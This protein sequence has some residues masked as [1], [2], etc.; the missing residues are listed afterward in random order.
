MESQLVASALDNAVSAATFLIMATA[1]LLGFLEEYAIF[2][3]EH[4]LTAEVPKR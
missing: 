1:A 3:S 4:Q 2:L